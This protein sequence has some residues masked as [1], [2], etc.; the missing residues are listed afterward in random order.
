MQS[1]HDRDSNA[2]LMVR[3]L[4]HRPLSMMVW[5]ATTALAG[6]PAIADRR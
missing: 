3:L 1:F 4:R 2:A 6:R 5:I